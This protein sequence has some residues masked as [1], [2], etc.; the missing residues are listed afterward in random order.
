M[1]I[2]TLL[3]VYTA[4]LRMSLQEGSLRKDVWE[5]QKKQLEV[6]DAS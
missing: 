5:Q 6:S 2:N 3:L 4:L 1:V